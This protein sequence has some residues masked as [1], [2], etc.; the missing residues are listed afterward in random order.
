MTETIRPAGAERR[1][2]LWWGESREW[3]EGHNAGDLLDDWRE[4]VRA[5][6]ALSQMQDYA[7]NET[8]IVA[9]GDVL[10]RAR[11][12]LEHFEEE[13]AMRLKWNMD[14]GRLTPFGDA[15]KPFLDRAELTPRKMLDKAGRLEEEHAEQTLLRHMHGPVPR[16]VGGYLMGFGEALDLTTAEAMSLTKG[17]VPQ[18]LAPTHPLDRVNGTLTRTADLLDD[19]PTGAFEKP[20]DRFRLGEL[21][22][23]AGQIVAR[24]EREGGSE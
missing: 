13:V 5:L 14:H 3:E 1:P 24:A 20:E 22:A 7:R 12:E 15:I 9:F 11:I 19:V 23:K 6:E 10:R 17:L 4:T 21:V 2:D 18:L 8:M 16:A